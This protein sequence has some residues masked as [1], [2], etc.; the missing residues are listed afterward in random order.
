MREHTSFWCSLFSDLIQR[1]YSGDIVIQTSMNH[2]YLI[3][4]YLFF[5]LFFYLQDTKLLNYFQH[6]L[7][8]T[9]NNALLVIQ[10]LQYLQRGTVA[11][12]LGQPFPDQVWVQALASWGIVLCFW[13]RQYRLLLLQCLSPRREVWAYPQI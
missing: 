11:S 2:V 5:H 4:F 6:K 12:W 1:S 10:H 7:F 13:A 8:Y 9:T 3:N